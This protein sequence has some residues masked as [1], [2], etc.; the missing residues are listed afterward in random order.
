VSYKDI[1][2]LMAD[3]KE[4]YSTVSEE[5]ALNALDKF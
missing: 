5:A 4:V 2:T 3:L 1:K